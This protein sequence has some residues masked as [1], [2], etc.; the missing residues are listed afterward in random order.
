MRQNKLTDKQ[1]S[2]IN[3]IKKGNTDG[4]WADIDQILERIEYTTTKESLQFSLRFLVKRGLIK[5]SHKEIR[6]GRLR[7]VYQPMMAAFEV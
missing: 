1:M 4:S 2:V 7:I 5:K 6:R 3:V